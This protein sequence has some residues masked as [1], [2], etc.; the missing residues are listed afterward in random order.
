MDDD[1]VC[2]LFEVLAEL[3]PLGPWVT[4]AACRGMPEVFADRPTGDERSMVE[5][6]CRRCPVLED[7]RDFAARHVVF[8]VYAGEFHQT[9][10][11][12]DTAA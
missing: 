2:A 1:A 7:C 6:V 3:P 8:G 11:R 5:R 4:E 10:Q 9:G 12:F